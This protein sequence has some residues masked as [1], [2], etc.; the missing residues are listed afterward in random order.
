MCVSFKD[1][2]AVETKH[3]GGCT[4]CGKKSLMLAWPRNSEK[5]TG[6]LMCVKW[7]P[8]I[9]ETKLGSRL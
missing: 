1:V 3:T 4:V 9:V 2:L 6:A 5:D 7:H 8:F